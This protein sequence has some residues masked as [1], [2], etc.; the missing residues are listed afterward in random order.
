MPFGS[1]RSRIMGTIF[2]HGVFYGDE[3]WK[4]LHSHDGHATASIN[5]T[6]GSPPKPANALSEV[7]FVTS[8]QIHTF[9]ETEVRP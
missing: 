8:D 5:A 7:T 6:A 9:R 2:H 1:Q 3:L 4:L